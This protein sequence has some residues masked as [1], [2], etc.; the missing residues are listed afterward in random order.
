MKVHFFERKPHDNQISIEKLFG[1]LKDEFLR[2]NIQVKNI[3]NPYS[4]K[5]MIKTGIYFRKNQGD[6]NHITGDI[7]WA[8]LFLDSKKTILTIHDLVGLKNLKGIK[9]R[10]YFLFWIYLPIKKLKYITVISSKTKKEIL[11]LL[12]WAENK[13][14]VIP[15]C[16]TIPVENE[17]VLS[18]NSKPM[19]LVIGS[20]K[21][22]NRGRLFRSI[23]G[24]DVKVIVIGKL[25]KRLT[26]FLI[27]NEIDFVNQT[28]VSEL[29][30]IDYYKKSDIL[31]FPSLY[32][33]FGLPIL[34]AQAQNCAVITSNKR[35]MNEVAGEGALLINPKSEEEM[36]EAIIKL[37]NDKELRK[38]LIIKGK[39]NIK[40][41]SPEIIAKKY[42][43]LYQEVLKNN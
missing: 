39:E 23:T 24:L 12:P 38:E 26:A 14:R 27:K 43:D 21:N 8:S 15:N 31:C 36:K 37:I 19:L 28:T 3:V 13:I 17:I 35:P 5:N 9:K 20:T 42:L 11:Y 4:L 6:I 25:S 29:E 41:Y 32:E 16:L 1:I 30:L 10:L 34:E 40:N 22:K 7:H 33:G 18:E 2:N